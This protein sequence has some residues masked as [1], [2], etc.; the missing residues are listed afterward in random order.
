MYT[1]TVELEGRLDAEAAAEFEMHMQKI[2]PLI[3]EV[4]LNFSKLTYISSMGLRSILQA[5][6]SLTKF[7]KKLTIIN[8]PPSV[9]SIF[10]M[11]GFIQAFV[12]EEKLVVIEKD[13]HAAGH[14]FTLAGKLTNETI[15]SL[16]TAFQG[17]GSSLRVLKL[18]CA[19]ITAV[20]STGC[21]ELIALRDQLADRNGRLML[22]HV[23]PAIADSIL[24]Q[25][26]EELL[27]LVQ[28]EIPEENPLGVQTRIEGTTK[29]YIYSGSWES[30]TLPVFDS[31]WKNRNSAITDVM[32]DLK[33]ATGVPPDA[34]TILLELKHRGAEQAVT[35][36]FSM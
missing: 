18:H 19:G 16:E 27:S 36:S 26:Y 33:S 23:P 12:R 11:S 24:Q 32:L 30:F 17:Q 20:D 7:H 10:E 29:R 21:E 6:K 2:D 35:V 31:E 13:E 3:K 9:R 1:H 34:F 14:I 5:Y 22:E 4:V 15:A 28:A 25:G 8:I